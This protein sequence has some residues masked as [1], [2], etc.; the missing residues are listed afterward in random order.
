MELRLER[1]GPDLDFATVIR[2]LKAPG[3]AVVQGEV[4]LEVEGEKATEEIASPVD[5]VIVEL[6]AAEGD[7][8]PVGALLALI[9]ER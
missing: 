6:V 4:I 5:G 7:E 1:L 8:L 2:W 3:D 9:E